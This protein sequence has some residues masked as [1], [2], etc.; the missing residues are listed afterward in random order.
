MASLR[1]MRLRMRSVKSISQ[2]TRAL[3]AVSA[4]KVRKAQQAVIGTRPYASKA[5]QVLQHLGLQ[6]GSASA[7]HPLLQK[8]ETVKTITVVL[9]TSDRG[10]CG[11]Y[12][13][14]IVRAALHFARAQSATVNFVAVGRKGR[15][16]LLRR[17]Q[18]L[19]GEFINLPGN[20]VFTDVSSIG[21]LVV[22][23]FL[24]GK[25]D[26]VYL[27]YTDYVNTLRQEPKV[28]QLLPLEPE[29][30]QHEGGLGE[31]LD[32]PERRHVASTGP[33][34]AYIYEPSQTSLLDTI[35]PRFTA[36]QIYQAI[37]EAMASEHSARMVAMRNATDSAKELLGNL[38]L[39]YNKARQL[40]ITS[41]LL[42]IVG[43][44][45]ALAKA[46]G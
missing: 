37:L 1:S 5:F 35:V 14:N 27:A 31:H 30:R 13:T 7:L 2:V 43:G 15:D 21:E 23:D 26:M 22:G 38:Q 25:T 12:N 28:R 41:D 17:R 36:L 3:E 42:D 24:S 20:P 8:H 45:E 4:S 40:S 46:S 6:P 39:Q 16:L 18:T 11:A 34:P 9:I 19:V 44:V 32:H 10:L 29:R 33:A